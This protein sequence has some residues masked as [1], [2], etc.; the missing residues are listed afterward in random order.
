MAA[1]PQ[2][3]TSN[4]KHRT[5]EHR[6]FTLVELMIVVA[7]IGILS[8]VA[9]PAFSR[10]IRRAK[11][12]EAIGIVNKLWAG[13][14]TYFEADPV[15][16]SGG[17]LGRRFPG[18]SGGRENA[19]ECG[20]LTGSACPGSSP[21][22]QTDPVWLGLN[23]SLA[24]THRYMPHYTSTGMGSSSQFSAMAQGDLDCDGT[25]SQFIRFGSVKNGDITGSHTPIVINELE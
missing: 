6:G 9:I 18:P 1:V 23:F 25:V 7:I 17:A 15:S 19:S 8:A 2:M 5:S 20:C 4:R 12:S 21:I 14:L 11:T 16:L 13:S 24:D 10:Y 3:K 22:W